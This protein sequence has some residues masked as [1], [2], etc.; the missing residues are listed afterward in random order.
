MLNATDLLGGLL[1]AGLGGPSQRRMGHAMGA[2]G[3]LGAILGQLGG[4]GRGS[5]G[6]DI[7]GQLSELTR[8]MGATGQGHAGAVRE[9]RPSARTSPVSGG[10]GPL[11][12]NMR[13]AVGAGGL[14][15]L[16]MLAMR[17]LRGAGQ[18]AAS[19]VGVAAA[20]PAEAEATAL[21][22]LRAMIDA[23]K[24]DGQI[25]GAEM[26]RILGK[27][28]EGGA[29]G[30]EKD[31]VL[32]EMRK[33]VDIEGL[34]AAAQTPELA[35]QTYAAALLAI[36]VDT[37]AERTYLQRLGSALRLEPAVVQELHAAVGAPAL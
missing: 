14:A 30:E 34:A 33:P 19:D 16:A 25:D 11:G 22:A 32:A 5:G 23:A 15:L 21:L 12:G 26:Q 4:G 1:R 24:A 20:D 18:P 6:G 13:G 28:D 7:L 27:L 31:F 2:G 9:T 8:S 10:G 17:A 3:P 29:D 35:A 37:D 36:E